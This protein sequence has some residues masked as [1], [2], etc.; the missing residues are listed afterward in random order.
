MTF[1]LNLCVAVSLTAGL[2]LLADL[3]LRS[4]P[5]LLRQRILHLGLGLLLLAPLSTMVSARWDLGL[6]RGDP[7]ATAP[8]IPETTREA[9]EMDAPA[10]APGQPSTSRPPVPATA[11]PATTPPSD[12]A[13]QAA[14][15]DS[16]GYLEVLAF[17]W[18]ASSALMI[19]RLALGQLL[20]WRFAA[21]QPAVADPAILRVVQ[22]LSETLG[23]PRPARLLQCELR[24]PLAFGVLRPT[25]CLPRN[26]AKELSATRLRGV[27][28][29]ELTHLRERH[30]ALRL[31][32]GLLRA[33][34][35]W[36]PLV[37]LF[38][39][40]LRATQEEVCD[41]QILQLDG[42]GRDFA[43]CLVE[44]ADTDPSPRFAVL[45]SGLL[46][47]RSELERRVRKLLSNERDIM[48]PIHLRAGL[49]LC[50][51]ALLTLG[52]QAGLQW[53]DPERVRPNSLAAFFPHREGDTW[54]M[55]VVQKAKQMRPFRQRVRVER[56][57][58]ARQ[59]PAS[60][61][62]KA[63]EYKIVQG[64]YLSWQYWAATDKGL[65]QYPRTYLGNLRGMRVNS[66]PTR[67]IP[68]PLGVT[69]SW[70]WTELM[71]VQT[72]GEGPFPSKDELT[73]HRTGEILSMDEE[74][75]VPLGKFR[76]VKIRLTRS[77]KYGGTPT[78]SSE[79]LW[80]VRGKGVVRR[81]LYNKG[82]KE[83]QRSEVM[84][85][86][87]AGR[88]YQ[89]KE[90][91]LVR[92][93]LDG[94]HE[95]GQKGS[96]KLSMLRNQA[97]D[98]CVG[99]R[100]WI[101]RFGDGR[102]AVVR[103]FQG[104]ASI[105]HPT[106]KDHWN[107]LIREEGTE[108][109][110]GT[111]PQIAEAYGVL[112]AQLANPRNRARAVGG[113]SVE[114]GKQDRI[115]V[116]LQVRTLDAGGNRARDFVEMDFLRGTIETARS[117]L[118]PQTAAI[119]QEDRP[120]QRMARTHEVPTLQ[121]SGK[122]PPRGYT[123][124]IREDFEGDKHGFHFSKVAKDVNGEHGTDEHGNRYLTIL[125]AQ[126]P[127]TPRA[128]WHHSYLIK[129]PARRV[130]L[131]LRFANSG[132]GLQQERTNPDPRSQ[133]AHVPGTGRSGW[134]ELWALDGKRRP[135]GKLKIPLRDHYD[136]KWHRLSEIVDWPEEASIVSITLR[137]GDRGWVSFD[138]LELRT[139]AR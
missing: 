75:E 20:L 9:P 130:Q 123:T 134:I 88:R 128:R 37:I 54:T 32:Q 59:G 50:A 6:L 69:T 30:P 125:T 17:V 79:I 91:T 10:A 71:S 126:R 98:T 101:A 48:R 116:K 78:E 85:E 3:A 39:R 33:L 87:R 61:G 15:W 64:R 80:L 115:R 89:G 43:R 35:F 38:D 92:Q 21:R 107:R 113:R 103:F 41:D 57:L 104:E 49:G 5:A 82:E 119:V 97:M 66:K 44:L 13:P 102:L 63:A 118:L 117:N 109:D 4:R 100:F 110:I 132:L 120:Q 27:L 106:S 40:S 55:E 139:Q 76:A 94:R 70:K 23:V 26:L 46:H 65:F 81:E 77:S 58:Q 53:Q 137:S 73:I 12:T 67:I 127:D 74:V 34:H 72:S 42:D 135:L 83:P 105:F 24:T 11:T 7:V 114:T 19:L 2:L 22:E 47:G 31:L 95:P 51:S 68:G 133:R 8:A 29:H 84:T 124:L 60:A 14:F 93:V 122:H 99:S 1:L 108:V 36:N 121:V 136:G 52:A 138:D 112:L 96:M 129:K 18:L 62:Y 90:L 16:L 131:Q 28:I 25:L 56:H 111:A 86:F 45:A